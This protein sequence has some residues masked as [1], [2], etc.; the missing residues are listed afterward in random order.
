MTL[1]L[2]RVKQSVKRTSEFKQRKNKQFSLV[3]CC[4]VSI[5]KSF[6]AENLFYGTEQIEK[7]LGSVG[8]TLKRPSRLSL[9]WQESD[10]FDVCGLCDINKTNWIVSM[11][12]RASTAEQANKK[13]L[14][15]ERKRKNHSAAHSVIDRSCLENAAMSTWFNAKR[16]G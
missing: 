12:V 10:L 8:Y 9:W 11:M 13:D 6:R 4:K 1:Q 14:H 2:Y 7:S 16:R 3:C 15:Q 5:C